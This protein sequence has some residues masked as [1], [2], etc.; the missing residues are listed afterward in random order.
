[1][2]FILY[3]IHSNTLYL[4]DTKS[5]KHKVKNST[6][7]TAALLEYD[8]FYNFEGKKMSHDRKLDCVCALSKKVIDRKYIKI[9]VLPAHPFTCDKKIS[10]RRFGLP[11]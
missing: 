5:P 2:D 4:K 7:Y 9:N 10:N 3:I 11:N 8:K 6:D 1:M